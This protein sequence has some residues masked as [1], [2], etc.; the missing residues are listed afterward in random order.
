[1]RK[2]FYISKRS[3]PSLLTDRFVILSDYV[4]CHKAESLISRI[5]EMAA[6]DSKDPIIMIFDC[7]GVT[8]KFCFKLF[9]EIKRC[10]GTVDIHGF[11]VGKCFGAGLVVLQACKTRVSVF[12]GV[13]ILKENNSF[14]S[15]GWQRRNGSDEANEKAKRIIMERSRLGEGRYAELITKEGV[16]DRE[17]S[18][19]EALEFGLIDRISN[20]FGEF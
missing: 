16:F 19:I 2:E 1:M 13:F 18:A 20:D 4:D 3:F 6:D 14:Q 9:N 5:N 15:G 7:E 17:F 10:N 11:V 8:R 12:A